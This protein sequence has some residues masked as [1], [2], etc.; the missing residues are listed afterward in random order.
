MVDQFPAFSLPF[1]TR[2]Q[3]LQHKKNTRLVAIFPNL[4]TLLE[5]TFSPNIVLYFGAPCDPNDLVLALPNACPALALAAVFITA[6]L[7]MMMSQE[8]LFCTPNL[9]S[10]TRLT[11]ITTT[12][13][14]RPQQLSLQQETRPTPFAKLYSPH[15]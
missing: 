13:A 14:T 11:T 7:N 15:S 5:L 9:P 4:Q 12:P 3:W 8:N 1:L 10:S 6:R 2:S